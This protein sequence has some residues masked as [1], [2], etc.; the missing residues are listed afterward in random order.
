VRDIR[1]ELRAG[2]PVLCSIHAYYSVISGTTGDTFFSVKMVGWREF[3]GGAND[4]CPCPCHLI[5]V[6]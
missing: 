4:P 5:E 3:L 6:E 2:Y 1:T